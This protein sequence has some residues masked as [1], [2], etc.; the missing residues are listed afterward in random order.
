MKTKLYFFALAISLFFIAQT[1]YTQVIVSDNPAAVGDP[2]AVLDIQSTTKGMLFP[3]MTM[4]ERNAIAL[5]PTSLVVYQIDGVVGLYYNTGAPAS[6][7][8]DK[9]TDVNTPAGY[10]TESGGNIYFN[11]GNVGIGIAAPLVP[12]HVSG[13]ARITG[14]LQLDNGASNGYVLAT[15]AIGNASWQDP[16]TLVSDDCDWTLSGTDVYS[17]VSGNVGIG[18][19]SPSVKLDVVGAARITAGL[20]LLEASATNG[21]VLTADASGNASWQAA[22]GGDDGD[23]TVSGNDVYNTGTGNVGIGS[24]TPSVKLD[25]VGAARITTGLQ[26][27]EGSASLGYVLTSDAS[28]NA[29]WADVDGLVSNDADWTISGNNI[30]SANTGNVGIGSSTPGTKLDVNGPGWFSDSIYVSGRPGRVRIMG[31]QNYSAALHYEYR[32]TTKYSL[33]H[34]IKGPGYGTDYFMFS[35]FESENNLTANGG[36]PELIGFNPD[37]RILQQYQGASAAFMMFSD[38]AFPMLYIDVNNSGANANGIQ[39]RVISPVSDIGSVCIGGWNKGEGKG[40]YGENDL[41]GNYGYLGT[42]NNGAYGQHGTSA[43]RGALGSLTSG[44]YG[45]FEAN[46]NQG[47]LGLENY[48]VQGT[49]GTSNFWAAL[50]TSNAG[51]YARLRPDNTSPQ[52]LVANDFAIKGLGVEIGTLNTNRGSSYSNQVGGVMGYNTVGTEYSAGVVGHTDVSYADRRTSGVFGGIENSTQWGALGYE[53]SGGSNYGGYF[54]NATGTGTGKAVSDPSSS[55]GIGVFGDLFGAHIDGQVYGLYA[56]GQNYGIY[57]HGDMYRTGAD[58]HLQQNANGEN[59]VMYTLVTTEMTV[60]TYGIGTMQQGKS[61][62]NFDQAFADVVS[63][64]E[65]II[66]TITP[67]GQ[68]KGVYL[69]QVDGNGFSVSENNNGKS[70]VQFSWIAI[71]KRKGFEN[72]SLPADVIASDYNAKIQQGLHNDADMN[73]DGEGLYYQDGM[74]HTGHLTQARSGSNSIA[75]TDVKLN[76]SALLER[77]MK[78]QPIKDQEVKE[79]IPSRRK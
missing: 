61:N 57:A 21:Y 27:L 33:Y 46:G 5:P 40:V 8:W 65:P 79:D 17:A 73:K 18:S 4:A 31:E 75:N 50:G 12:L 56:S 38:A 1:T 6:P 20:Q 11:T 25:V 35:S 59:T 45:L 29:S 67:V 32:D 16:N 51:V 49:N 53:S 43:N 72:M 60:Q 26:L 14:A 34:R 3:R 58:V 47:T 23:W 36:T 7:Q 48:G 69:E 22:P 71:G 77:N 66:V 76:R 37:G 9:I 78:E 54:S 63:T 30:Y 28:G 70:D 39:S 24:S 41:Y 68:T 52:T 44:A 74:L 55:I 2:A 42:N 64:N 62:I 10:W 15:D 13:A 19:M